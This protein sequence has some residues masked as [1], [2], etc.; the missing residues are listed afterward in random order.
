MV[1]SNDADSRLIPIDPVCVGD[2]MNPT[3][4]PTTSKSAAHLPLGA[5]SGEDFLSNTTTSKNPFASILALPTNAE[6]EK[7][8]PRTFSME[9][10][11]WQGFKPVAAT[12]AIKPLGRD[13]DFV[14]GIGA[15]LH[16]PSA[17]ESQAQQGADE[18]TTEH[19]KLE[20]TAQKWVAQTFFGTLMKQMR[21]SPF[22]SKMFDG[23]RGGEAFT[24]MFDQKLIEHMSR[25]SGKKLVGNI[26]RRLE[27]KK[28]YAKGQTKKD[29]TPQDLNTLNMGERQNTGALNAMRIHVPPTR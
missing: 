13:T 14:N 7:S 11:F 18:A 20:K 27:A 25:S 4:L 12:A 8:H 24:E 21:N 26:V 16:A 5:L 23:G 17:T 6:A 1:L 15:A 2:A 10:D 28:A 29:L 22:K 9:T 19:R 3:L